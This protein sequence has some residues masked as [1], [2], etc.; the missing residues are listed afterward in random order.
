MEYV[1]WYAGIGLFAFFCLTVLCI[2]DFDPAQRDRY[3]YKRDPWRTFF[4]R[5]IVCFGLSIIW[6]FTAL[7]VGVR[8]VKVLAT[9]KKK[10]ESDENG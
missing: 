9:K 2:W 8:R 4:E 6:P 7:F 10:E 3:G 1:I 5:L